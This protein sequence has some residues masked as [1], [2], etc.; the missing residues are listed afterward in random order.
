MS[1]FYIYRLILPEITV[2]LSGI[3]FSPFIY[4]ITEIEKAKFIKPCIFEL[5]MHIHT[6]NDVKYFIVEHTTACIVKNF[7]TLLHFPF[8][9]VY[10]FL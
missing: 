6:Y 8:T 3:R 10:I 4:S 5:K 9:D 7:P 1:R 2:I